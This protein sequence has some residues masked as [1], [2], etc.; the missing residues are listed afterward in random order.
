VGRAGSFEFEN[1]VPGSYFLTANAIDADRVEIFGKIPIDVGNAD[2]GNLSVDLIPGFDLRI[3]LTIEGRSRRSDDPQ[4]VVNL[5]PA[6]PSTPFPTVERKGDVELAMHRFMP[7]DYS[8]AVLS[9]TNARSSNGSPAN[10][11]L[12]LKSAQY[13]G[14][15]VLTTGLHIEA[16]PSGILDI[17]MADGAGSLS[18]AVLDDQ[19]KPASG[20]TV[21]L[22]P[23]PR[24]R[25]R[26]DLYKTG[27]TD[28]GG[29]F[30][31]SGIAP[32]QYKVFSWE[33]AAQGSWQYPDF[34]DPYEDRGQSVRIY[35]GKSDPITVQLIPPR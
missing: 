19:K 8:V 2:V 22:I 23:E 13:G 15:D 28:A 3:R 10:G 30:E 33:D 31:I 18:G 29:E 16:S 12:Y 17:V 20:L 4:L 21:V 35:G 1:V 34:L 5:R 6:I 11:S 26:S 14:A 27:M 9:L 25:G 7:G 32:G 24:L